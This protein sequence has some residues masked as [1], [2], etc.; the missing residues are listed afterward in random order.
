MSA[1][2]EAEDILLGKAKAGD[3]KAMYRHVWSRPETAEFMLWDV[4]ENE[5]E[6]RKRIQKTILF[7]ETHEAFLVYE[8]KSGQAIGFAGIMKTA[9]DIWEDTGIALGPEY[10]G[11]GY[12]KQIVKLLLQYCADVLNG[13]EFH[14]TTRAENTASKALAQSCG[15]RFHHSEQKRHPKS[16]ETYEMEVYNRVLQIHPQNPCCR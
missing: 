12:G 3:W 7:Q 4:T 2:L 6:A 10:V 13:K 9:P 1:E 15:F 8:K 14:Y 16:G 11:K 5:E